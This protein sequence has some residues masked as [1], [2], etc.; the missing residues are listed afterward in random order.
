MSRKI[1]LTVTDPETNALVQKISNRLDLIEERLP[2]QLS[3]LLTR[4]QV[5]EMLSV[6]VVTIIDWDKKGVL[7]PLRIGN[8]VRYQLIEIEEILKSSRY[9]S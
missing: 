6:S 3:K 2:K 4:K 1:E 7:K 5:S 9:E 8:R